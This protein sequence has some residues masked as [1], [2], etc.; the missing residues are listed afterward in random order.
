VQRCLQGAFVQLQNAQYMK[1]AAFRG[2]V[3]LSQP[4]ISD[5]QFLFY[6]ITPH[7]MCAGL[8]QP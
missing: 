2:S 1:E 3:V 5:I 4:D 8:G 6:A 7:G